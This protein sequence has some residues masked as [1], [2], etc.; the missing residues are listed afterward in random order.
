MNLTANVTYFRFESLQPVTNYNMTLIARN[1]A[2][3]SQAAW[4][5]FQTPAKPP[6]PPAAAVPDP[7]AD[8]TSSPS[9]SVIVAVSASVAVG[10]MLLILAGAGY[11]LHRKQ[12]ADKAY[13]RQMQK[14]SMDLRIH[15][16]E[17]D[18]NHLLNKQQLAAGRQLDTHSLR[19][20]GNEA[21][22]QFDRSQTYAK[23]VREV[24]RHLERPPNNSTDNQA[25]RQGCTVNQT[26]S[27]PQR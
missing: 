22:N 13:D 23:I 19:P 5:T 8:D 21:D 18:R 3:A 4:H 26:D 20:A 11:W 10:V 12:Q 6:A 14:N 24:G 15:Y 2:G 7:A 27:R 1:A 17:L 9:T 16:P 25:D